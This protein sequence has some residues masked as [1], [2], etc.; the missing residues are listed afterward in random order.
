MTIYYS[1][2]R[3]NKNKPDKIKI[4]TIDGHEQKVTEFIEVA[5]QVRKG[6]SMY[7]EK[8]AYKIASFEI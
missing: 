1:V 4:C 3:V 8:Y 5:E 7:Y 2:L 6:L